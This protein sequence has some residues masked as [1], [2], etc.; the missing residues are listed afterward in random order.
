MKT[1][2]GSGKFIPRKCFGPVF[3]NVAARDT[4]NDVRLKK[5]NR[6]PYTGPVIQLPKA[7]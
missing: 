6:A 5:V 7:T 3:D 4:F 2:K 1:V